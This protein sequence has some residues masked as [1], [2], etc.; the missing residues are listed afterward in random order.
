ME[1]VRYI[2][3]RC[4]RNT[5]EGIDYYYEGQQYTVPENHP[6]MQHF[7]PLREVRQTEV[8]ERAQEKLELAKKQAAPGY[9]FH[10][11]PDPLEP[12]PKQKLDPIIKP[13]AVPKNIPQ[14]KPKPKAK[15]KHRAKKA[16]K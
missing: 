9:G 13:V 3:V 16:S 5:A 2:E 8:D 4:L 12:K 15:A 6:C 11:A 10:S 1:E 7:E 14:A